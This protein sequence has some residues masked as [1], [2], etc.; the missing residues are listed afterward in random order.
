MLSCPRC[1]F[2][3]SFKPGK[4]AL[5]SP[6][7]FQPARLALSP[8]TS[9]SASSPILER[10]RNFHTTRSRLE[11][12]STA[13]EPPQ[14]SQEAPLDI[15]PICCPGC[16]AYAQTIDPNEPGYYSKTRKKTRKLINKSKRAVEENDKILDPVNEEILRNPTE[17]R[18]K[19]LA[20]QNADQEL[21]E[22]TAPRPSHS[23]LVED[24]ATAEKRT[25]IST[26]V[27]EVAAA[28]KRFI[29]DT[30]SPTQVCDRC[31]NLIHHNKGTPAPFPTI[32]SIRHFLDESP[33]KHNRVYH[34]LDAADFPMSL[35]PDI[36]EALGLQEQ[37]SRNR[38]AKT[39]KYRGGRKLPTIS[40]VITRSDLLAATKEQVDSK[41]QYMRQ[42]LRD[43]LG[44]E[45][46]DVRLGN[47]HM[48][49][50][51]RGWWTKDVKE[52]IRGHGG[53]IWVVGKAN[54]GKSSFIEA[55]FPKDSRN[56]EKLADLL[57][58]RR[59]EPEVLSKQRDDAL[60][61]SDSLLPPAPREDLYPT[62]PIVSSLP[63]TTVSPIRIPFGRGKGEMIDLP[64]LE[65]GSLQ[66][67]IRDEHKLDLIMTKRG[68]PER[69]TIKPGQ[70]L[71]LGGGLI[72]IT[73]VDPESP[74]MAA[75][76]LPLEAHVTKT[77]KAIEMQAQRRTYPGKQ[78]I[79]KEGVGEVMSSAG[80]FELK[81]DATESHL[82]TTFKKRKEDQGIP[83]PPMPYKVM[84]ADL[85]IEGSGWVELT[86]QVRTKTEPGVSKPT[87]KVEVFSPH[88]QHVGSRMP[89]ETWN[90]IHQKRISDKRKKGT[91]PA[92]QNISQKKR[93]QHTAKL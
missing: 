48:I 11:T 16:G 75:C 76:F 80:V 92:R 52:E 63:G 35:V 78:N 31:H 45:G 50:A 57:E 60:L 65:R 8:W 42:V 47:V 88:G 68:N 81:W 29:E 91:R 3:R 23:T 55:C 18:K 12:S 66:D 67:F 24:I 41:M 13:V 26:S 17:A 71:L 93:A 64:G 15:L 20:L 79:L 56:L 77:E 44:E 25:P 22:D 9:Y 14:E 86:E 72:R 21:P 36:Y 82:P 6:R 38:R 7:R 54:V 40:F 62:L 51:H 4:R 33:H 89:I 84:A 27:K 30:V 37:R 39:E 58:S 74:V 83:P 73:P 69:Y 28:A 53:G 59:E 5:P 2:L 85:L 70:S 90:F 49:S 32:H 87:P 1:V 43:A 46:E 19:A 34:I 10:R 61:D